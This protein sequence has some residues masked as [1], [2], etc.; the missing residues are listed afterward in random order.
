MQAR[1]HFH[2]ECSRRDAVAAA[3]AV[4]RQQLEELL[5]GAEVQHIGSTAVPGSLTKGDLDIN[6]R[7]PPGEFASTAAVLAASY[8]A[9]AGSS[10][11]ATFRSFADDAARPPLGI[12]LTAISGPEDFFCLIRDHLQSHPGINEEY[13]DL[14]RRCEGTDMEDYRRAKSLFLEDLLARLRS[15][16]PE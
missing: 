13:N 10:R 12:Q 7:V 16:T 11:S 8:P 5:P 2:S 6:I 9:N 15:G 1:V 4:H 3:F 14:K